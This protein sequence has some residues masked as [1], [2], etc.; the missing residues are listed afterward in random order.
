MADARTAIDQY[1][2]IEA[3]GRADAAAAIDEQAR[4]AIDCVQFRD[5]WVDQAAGQLEADT[6]RFLGRA[7]AIFRREQ[8]HQE[9]QRFEGIRY[10]GAF[11]QF[12]SVE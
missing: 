8:W 11:D 2:F 6:S 10:F 1:E 5:G 9:G 4:S 3:A 7:P 12:R